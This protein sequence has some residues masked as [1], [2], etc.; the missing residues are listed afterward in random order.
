MAA[1]QISKIN[2]NEMDGDK[3]DQDYVRTETARLSCVSWAVLKLL[4]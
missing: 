2:R 1:T 4:V 3:I